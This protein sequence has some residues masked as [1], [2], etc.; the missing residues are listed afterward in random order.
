MADEHLAVPPPTRDA[1]IALFDRVRFHPLSIAVLARQLRSR[2]AGQLGE[3][4]DRILAGD[5]VS[6][7]TPAD[8]GTPKSLI[9]SLLLSL[10]RLDDQQRAL[11]LRLGV[12]QGGAFEENL[13]AITGL[14]QAGDGSEREALEAMR[15]ALDS[16]DLR[17]L[18]RALGIDL[19]AGAEVPA[20]LAANL[21]N[22][23]A[24]EAKLEPIRARLAARLAALPDAAGATVGNPWPGLRRE[25]EAAALIEAERVPGVGPPFLR[26]HPTL[27]PGAAQVWKTYGLLAEIA[28]RESRSEQAADYRRQARDAKRNYAGTSHQMKQFAPLIAVVA[29][30]VA[31]DQAARDE[32]GQWLQGLT[33][34]GA[35]TAKLAGAIERLVAGDRDPDALCEGLG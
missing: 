26:F 32:L 1:L 7:M 9:A 15:S 23:P 24:I 2:P 11:A 4:L 22:N 28:D 19:P 21:A 31:G 12:F 20:E 35:E 3:H 18:L 34:A 10:E 29:G 30:A 25:L 14:G 33:E 16:G 17:A 5:A 13:L 27:D 6:P 8:A